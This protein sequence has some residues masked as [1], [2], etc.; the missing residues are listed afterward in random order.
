MNPSDEFLESPKAGLLRTLGFQDRST[1]IVVDGRKIP[2]SLFLHVN[3]LTDFQ[4]TIIKRVLDIEATQEDYSAAIQQIQHQADQLTRA[5]WKPNKVDGDAVNRPDHYERF[6]IEPTFFARENGITW[7]L[8]N[9]LK[10]MCRFPFKNGV[11]DLRKAARYLAME[12]RFLD[13]LQ[14][15]SR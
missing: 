4:H 2:L 9:F 1:G 13:G 14:D 8:G 7:N 3:K 5:N 6:A 12:V 11:E 15:W 10:Y